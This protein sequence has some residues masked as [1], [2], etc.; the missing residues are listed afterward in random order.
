[1]VQS[2][3]DLELDQIRGSDLDQETDLVYGPNLDQDQDPV[4]V[5]DRGLGSNHDHSSETFI[6]ARFGVWT[7]GPHRLRTDGQL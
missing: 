6:S 7:I 3:L 4:L 2:G 1:M 5:P